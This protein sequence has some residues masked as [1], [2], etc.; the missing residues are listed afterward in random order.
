[1]TKEPEVQGVRPK[2]AQLRVSGH[3]HTG[4]CPPLREWSRVQNA[5]SGPGHTAQ[6]EKGKEPT[7]QGCGATQGV[8]A[9]GR[10]HLSQELH[11]EG[12]EDS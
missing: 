7:E 1:M 11:L 2:T 12:S 9:H 3:F 5:H 6:C 8:S 4:W 10:Q